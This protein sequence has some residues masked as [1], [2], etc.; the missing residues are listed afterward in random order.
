MERKCLLLVSTS[1][2]MLDNQISNLNYRVTYTLFHG[3]NTSQGCSTNRTRTE[4]FFSEMSAAC[5]VEDVW[6]LTN[7]SDVINKWNVSNSLVGL[8]IFLYK[9]KQYLL[10]TSIW[11]PKYKNSG[12]ILT[13][14]LVP[15]IGD[16]LD[17]NLFPTHDAL[18]LWA[19]TS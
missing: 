5:N 3:Y 9:A 18:Q 12:N 8:L 14:L 4:V 10:N 7:I 1:C 13:H 11:G 17:L 6:D 15:F 16:P 2:V 19:K